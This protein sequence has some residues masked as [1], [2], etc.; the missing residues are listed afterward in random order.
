M[1]LDQNTVV[2]NGPSSVS[3]LRM[4]AEF[5][6]P[7]EKLVDPQSGMLLIPSIRNSNAAVLFGATILQDQQEGRF[8][9]VTP[10]RG[11]LDS[12]RK[13]PEG[14]HRLEYSWYLS[15]PDFRCSVLK[16]ESSNGVESLI[17]LTN[18]T[19]RCIANVRLRFT[20]LQRP[21]QSGYRTVSIPPDWQIDPRSLTS[22]PQAASGLLKLDESGA[23][24][25]IDTN[26]WNIPE[27]VVEFQLFRALESEAPIDLGQSTW[28][29][30]QDV[31]MRECVYLE[32]GP[33]N[34]FT[35][36]GPMGQWLL[37]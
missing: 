14:A 8:V 26:Q 25:Q 37:D 22:K 5:L 2:V 33:S 13:T 10:E 35:F 27:A 3:R 30:I 16:P 28:L 9:E 21:G 20:Q 32:P 24:L 29:T 18:D 36:H 31:P 23:N 11:R 15:P 7:W 6:I 17:R 1:Q 19:E 34:R 12:V 4:A